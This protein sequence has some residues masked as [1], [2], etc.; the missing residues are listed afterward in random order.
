LVG[1]FDIRPS[2][3][4]LAGRQYELFQQHGLLK[5]DSPD[6]KTTLKIT[7]TE[8]NFNPKNIKKSRFWK[9]SF[10]GG[11]DVVFARVLARARRAKTAICRRSAL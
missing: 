8:P 3:G 7:L 10:S 2:N 9:K 5:Q 11:G 4:A 6:D 1:R